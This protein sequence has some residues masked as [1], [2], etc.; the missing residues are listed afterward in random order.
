[1][2]VLKFF[3][4][5]SFFANLCN[6]N[7]ITVSGVGRIPNWIIDSILLS[8]LT[9]CTIQMIIFCLVHGTTLVSI[10]SAIYLI[11]AFFSIVSMYICFAIKNDLLIITIDHLQETVDKRAFTGFNFWTKKYFKTISISGMLSSFESKTLYENRERWIENFVKK[12]IYYSSFVVVS[13]FLPPFLF[14]IGYAIAGFPTPKQWYLPFPTAFV[15][16]K[17]KKFI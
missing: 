11:L 9:I 1:M 17:E 3:E 6:K 13:T 2:K 10:S 8:S 15:F 7:G 14:P 16:P 12:M 4:K 5:V